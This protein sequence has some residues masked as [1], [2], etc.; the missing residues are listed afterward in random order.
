MNYYGSK[1]LA[2]AFRTVRTNTIKIAEDIPES[3][4]EFRP[5]PDTR[6]VAQSLTHIALS[7]RFQERLQTSK[8]SD[9]ATLNFPDLFKDMVAEE[10]KPRTK[11]EIIALLKSEG[12]SYATFLEGLSETFLAESVKMSPQGGGGT[13]TRFEMLLGPKEHEMHHRGQLM[14]IQRMLGQVPHLTRQMQER[15]A[16]AQTGAGQQS[17]R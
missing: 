2:G 5:A 15:M 13:K 3:Q 9:L 7:T 8:V 12:D 1:E 17:Q 11:S 10:A 14:T 6:T 16:Q 4:Y